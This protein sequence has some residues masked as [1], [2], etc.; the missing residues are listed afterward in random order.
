MNLNWDFIVWRFKKCPK[1]L[2]F[3]DLYNF[4]EEHLIPECIAYVEFL[5]ITFLQIY[6][7]VIPMQIPILLV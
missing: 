4:I 1:N 3:E 2:R 7:V 5:S 6:L